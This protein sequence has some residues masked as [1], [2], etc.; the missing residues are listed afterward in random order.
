[1]FHYESSRKID[2]SP[3]IEIW[4][5]TKPELLDLELGTSGNIRILRVLDRKLRI[6]PDTLGILPDTPDLEWYIMCLGLVTDP[7]R[8]KPLFTLSRALSHSLPC[9][10][11]LSPVLT[12]TPNP[13][14]S[15]PSLY[16]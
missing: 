11:S 15:K 13:R 12:L 14:D 3:V 4:S 2:P 9:A 10:L 8:Y 1:M 7:K 6:S 5:H 16:P